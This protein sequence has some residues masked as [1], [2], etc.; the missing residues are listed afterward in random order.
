MGRTVPEHAADRIVGPLVSGHHDGKIRQELAEAASAANDAVAI[1]TVGPAGEEREVGTAGV[2]PGGRL[3]FE[4]AGCVDTHD[5]CASR[6]ARSESG[7]DRQLTLEP[8]DDNSKAPARARGEETGGRGPIERTF[9]AQHR[10]PLGDASGEVVVSRWQR[11]PSERTAFG[12]DRN[13]LDERA[14]DVAE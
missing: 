4:F 5:S 14:A 12:V 1:A 8:E 9:R 13:E 3:K 6:R 10:L 11:A 7:L 2:Q